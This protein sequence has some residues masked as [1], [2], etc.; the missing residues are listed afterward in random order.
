MQKVLLPHLTAAVLP[1]Q[2]H[3]AFRT[4]QSNHL[5]TQVFERLEISSRATAEI[6]NPVRSF[7]VEMLEKGV[8]ILADVVIPRA[9]PKTLG[10][11]IVMTERDG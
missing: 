8:A 2:F 10:L 3:E 4:L 7:A 1:C 6:E 5:L 9:P 11:L